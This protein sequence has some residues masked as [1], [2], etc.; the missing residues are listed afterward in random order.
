MATRIFLFESEKPFIDELT[1]G[2]ARQGVKVDVS[3]DGNGGVDI[4]AAN[5]PDLI[6]L[7]VELPSVN[8]FLVCKKIKKTPA[9]A[10]VPLII[11]SND[12]NA[13]EIF[14]QHKK[15][16]TRAEDYLKKPITFEQVLARVQALI[17]I[18]GKPAAMD[19]ETEAQIFEHFRSLT[20]GRIA[21]LI[22]HRFSTV[23][24]ADQIVVLDEGRIVEHGSHDELM[25]LGG[26]YAHLFNLQARA[27]R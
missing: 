15:L 16:R 10:E 27:Y 23:R 25:A 5:K 6:M 9:I 4:A 11:L 19:A 22:S 17:P 26:R 7:T 14:E 21:I 12:A 18:D 20:Q 1:Q 2:F 13:D 3:A 24:Y 8:G